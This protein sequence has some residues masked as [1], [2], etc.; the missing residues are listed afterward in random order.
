MA[1][2]VKILSVLG[3]VDTQLIVGARR[4]Y[5][6]RRSAEKASDA[7]SVASAS[8]LVRRMDYEPNAFFHSCR[9]RAVV[10]ASESLGSV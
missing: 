10:T 5:A 7:F 6:S 9:N 1:S 4:Q 2:A 3:F 8:D